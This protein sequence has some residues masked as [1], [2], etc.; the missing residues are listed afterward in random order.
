MPAGGAGSRFDTEFGPAEVTHVNLNDGVVEG[1]ALIDQPA[2][3][4]QYHPEAAP[5]PNDAKGLFI[6]FCELIERSGWRAQ[7]S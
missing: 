1:L 7:A 2:F 5:G 6:E 4:V 3:A